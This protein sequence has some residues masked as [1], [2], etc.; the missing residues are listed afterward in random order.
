MKSLGIDLVELERI[1]TSLSRFGDK[2]LDKILTPQEQKQA[3]E[4]KNPTAFVAGRFAAKE[5]VAKALQTG[6]G[7]H[8]AFHDIEITNNEAGAP[9]VTLSQAANQHFNSPTLRLSIS[10]SKTAAT[11]V[12]AIA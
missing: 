4:H 12:A 2:F 1:E 11:A 3:K 6:F 9:L 7:K 5:A 10:H 8:L